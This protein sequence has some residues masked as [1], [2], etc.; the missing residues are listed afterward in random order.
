MFRLTRSN[1]NQ[2]ERLA[3][4]TMINF[5]KFDNFVNKK[6]RESIIKNYKDF[7]YTALYLS[8]KEEALKH[9]ATI[10]EFTSKDYRPTY[11]Y[12]EEMCEILK[13]PIVKKTAVLRVV[14]VTAPLSKM[15]DLSKKDFHRLNLKYNKEYFEAVRLELYRISEYLHRLY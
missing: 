9:S 13:L 8:L 4:Y 2:I 6:E 5:K 3:N 10:A 1:V 14:P 7:D 15:F 12:Y 11:P